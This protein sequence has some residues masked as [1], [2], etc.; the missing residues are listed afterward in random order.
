[1]NSVKQ[2]IPNTVSGVEP[3]TGN[4]SNIEDLQVIP[5]IKRYMEM[6]EFTQLSVAD[7][8]KILMAE[9]DNGKHWWCIG[10][11]ETPVNDL[12]KWR[13]NDE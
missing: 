6:L 9:Y 3:E 7:N 11:F 4:F 10:Y 1:M 5:F 2:H 13:M 12:P 8:G